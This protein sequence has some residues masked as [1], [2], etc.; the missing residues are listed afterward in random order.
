MW[1]GRRLALEP[2]EPLGPLRLWRLRL[3]RTIIDK[4][5]V[6]LKNY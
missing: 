3:V 4:Q 2:L 6:E 1:L 5:I